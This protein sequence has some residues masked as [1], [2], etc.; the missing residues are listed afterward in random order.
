MVVLAG[1]SPASLSYIKQKEKSAV[2]AGIDFEL[3]Q[4]SVDIQE[5]ELIKI[6]QDINTDASI[7]GVIVQLP[8]P[9]HIETNTVIETIDPRKDVDG[10]TAEN[11]G[12][13]FL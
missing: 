10:F 4:Y 6:I 9:T 3:R 7:D 13:L 5:E 1:D 2:L 8:L 11:I 12:K